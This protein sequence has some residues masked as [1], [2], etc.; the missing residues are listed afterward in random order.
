MAKIELIHKGAEAYLYKTYML[1]IPVI[2]KHRI[3]KNYRDRTLDYR[4]RYQRTILEAKIIGTL[5][6]KGLP[7][8]AILLVDPKRAILVLEY[9]EG[10]MLKELISRN[11]ELSRNMFIELGKYVGIMHS[12]NIVHGDLT[13]SNVIVRQDDNKPFIIDFGLAH[14]SNDIED[15][16]VD[17][18]LMLR[19]LES[20]HPRYVDTLFKEF[21][22][23][24]TSVRGEEY[25]RKLLEKVKEI[26]MRG[27]Y[28]EERRLKK[29]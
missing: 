7:V 13:T 25:T 27:R 12:E 20:T 29:I 5:R 18:H 19:S 2:V 21:L 24:Y 14:Y 3:P 17:I 15:Q 11:I 8:P 22:K 4:I 16:G 6:L 23:G 9:I 26:R 1:G 10:V 28:I